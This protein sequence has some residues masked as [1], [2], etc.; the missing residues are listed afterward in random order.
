MGDCI[1]DACVMK[2]AGKAS[3]VSSIQCRATLSALL[4]H[5]HMLVVERTIW[6]E[7]QRHHTTFSLAWQSAMVSR[8]QIVHVRSNGNHDHGISQSISALPIG[9]QSTANKDRH[10][11]EIALECRA[12]VISSEVACR[13][14]FVS[15]GRVY[16]PIQEVHWV[17][18]LTASG[19]LV[20][21]QQR[22]RP[23]ISWLLV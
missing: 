22:G 14:A 13:T 5:R 2:Q 12:V 8:S 1:V 4:N 15:C 7:W 11:L 23:P 16:A 19:L 21:L 20:W 9:Q 17:S 18:P 3:D 10:L 6:D